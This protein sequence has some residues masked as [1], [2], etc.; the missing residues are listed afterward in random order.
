MGLR[1]LCS[2]VRVI[3]IC[4]HVGTQFFEEP[5]SETVPPFPHWVI[6]ALLPKINWAYMFLET[7][8][9]AADPCLYLHTVVIIII[10]IKMP[11][12]TFWS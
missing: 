3:V 2:E 1:V 11:F 4:L 8:F 6:L 12:N 5:L 9:Y 7:W 10:I